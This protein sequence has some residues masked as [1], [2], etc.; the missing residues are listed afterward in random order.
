MDSTETIEN[1]VY[2]EDIDVKI[3]DEKRIQNKLKEASQSFQDGE[4]IAAK[5]LECKYL[6]Y[7]GKNHKIK[8]NHKEYNVNRHPTSDYIGNA[9]KVYWPVFVLNLDGIKKVLA[10]DF[11]NNKDDATN[12]IR[13]LNKYYENNS[14]KESFKYFI[15]SESNIIQ[16]SNTNKYIKNI[17]LNNKFTKNILLN[18]KHL[19][20]DKFILYFLT[21]VIS[22]VI[23]LLYYA[24]LPDEISVIP[25]ITIPFIL[26]LIP[27]LLNYYALKISNNTIEYDIVDIDKKKII[28]SNEIM[29]KDYNYKSIEANVTIN[30]SGLK[31]ESEELNCEWFYK[32][33]NNGR[34]V[35][36]GIELINNLIISD[37]N[38]ILTV[39]DTGY[40]DSD[41][42]C[43]TGEWWIDTESIF[44]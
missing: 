42:M 5:V 12:K 39:K 44:N 1:T 31:I 29:D 4:I 14:D 21:T 43:S 26:G 30:E 37:G 17:L 18:D 7:T 33:K 15:K 19:R 23:I 40:D 28:E 13:S 41:W 36:P 3:E 2:K 16:N 22:Y 10:C 8:Y 9:D 34:L 20:V 24:F 32:R 27:V 35:T 25:L 11:Y 38:C 6:S